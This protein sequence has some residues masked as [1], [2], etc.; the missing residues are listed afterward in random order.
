M[1][2]S[3]F[4]LEEVLERTGIS[5]KDF[6]EWEKLKLIKAEGRTDGDTPLFTKITI[7][8]IR[9]IKIYSI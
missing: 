3:L 9:K 8:K 5:E 7:E 6:N 4:V 1:E 2:K